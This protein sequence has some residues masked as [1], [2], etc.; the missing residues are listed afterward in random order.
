MISQYIKPVLVF[1][2]MLCGYNNPS[3]KEVKEEVNQVDILDH[4]MNY[5]SK[6]KGNLD[7]IEGLW[8]LGVIRTLYVYGEKIALESE[9][10][11]MVLAVIKEGDLFRIY[12]ENGVP[13]DYIASF[14]QTDRTDIYAYECYFTETKDS[15]A[16]KVSLFSNSQFYYEYDAPK[17]IMMN[18]YFKAEL[19]KD[20]IKV[21]KSI[22]EG[23]IRLKWQ[24]SGLKYFPVESN[25]TY[26]PLYDYW[27]PDFPTISKP[28]ID[29]FR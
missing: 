18:Y 24:F 20:S 7:P 17:G 1:S 12:D 23:N 19:D 11:R 28:L 10:N 16:S 26:Y 5:L 29:R 9:P 3:D 21:K 15:V 27:V 22:E 2:L 4:I 8:S 6:N 25:K 14:K 13:V